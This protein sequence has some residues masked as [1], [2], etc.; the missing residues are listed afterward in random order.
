MGV[1]ILK[2]DFHYIVG[3]LFLR[4]SNLVLSSRIVFLILCAKTARMMRKKKSRII[5]GTIIVK[6]RRIDKKL[7]YSE[8]EMHKIEYRR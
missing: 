6:E 2:C 5:S 1:N 3:H 7:K 8:R 4:S